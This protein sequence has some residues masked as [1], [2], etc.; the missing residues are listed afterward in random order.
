MM[1]CRSRPLVY[2]GSSATG[3]I[4]AVAC[5]CARNGTGET[6]VGRAAGRGLVVGGAVF[7]FFCGGPSSW[8]LVALDASSSRSIS[9]NTAGTSSS[10]RVLFPLRA[11]LLGVDNSAAWRDLARAPAM[12]AVTCQVGAIRGVRSYDMLGRLIG[13]FWVFMVGV[14]MSIS[15]YCYMRH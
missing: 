9:W 15:K 11:D 10:D 1:V 3:G 6:R 14:T 8:A 12:S 5:A 13:Q 4:V 7:L 2:R